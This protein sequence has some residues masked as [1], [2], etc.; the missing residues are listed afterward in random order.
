MFQLI[1]NI[2]LDFRNCFKRL[3]TW[4]WFVI[5]VTGFMVRNDHRG[6][7]S[8]ISSLR[9]R[10]E[11]YNTALH[12]FRS[13]GYK[14]GDL[15][16]KWVKI[17]V[18][19]VELVRIADR[20]VVLGDHIKVSKEGR[21][22][23]WIQKLHQESQNSGKPTFIEGNIFG[24]VSAIQTN[25]TVSRSLPLKTQLQASPPRV[26]GT[27]KPDGDTLVTQMVNLVYEVAK[28]IGEPVVVALDAYFSNAPAWFAADKTI[29]PNGEKLVE[30]V[31]RA[32]SNT[33]AFTVPVKPGVKK[34][35]RPRI[36]GDRVALY[37]LFSNMSKFTQTTLMLYGKPT[38]VQYRC[39]DL[40]WKPVKRL[41]RFVAVDLDGRR[42][43]LMSTS[44]KLTAE[45]IITI[46]AFRFKIETSFAEQKNDI[47]SFAYHFWTMALPKRKK[48]KKVELPT[49]PKLQK[50]I[51]ATKQATE[52]FVCLC[53]I[54]TG[55]LSI[56]AFSHSCDIWKR[57]PG[58]IRTLRSTIPTIAIVKVTLAND[59]HGFLDQLL[60]LPVFATIK[61]KMRKVEFLFENVA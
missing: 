40:I 59:I 55:I 24:Q 46:Y 2:L 9:L 27:K 60:Y 47:G 22:M 35:G 42:C 16:E 56:I 23:P 25:G 19:N 34:P 11:L 17:V 31:T 44:L 53:T 5:L 12:F 8:V 48:W 4:K 36:Y 50:K 43:V 10:P 14:V 32:Q 1:N 6:V 38:K 45:E 3:A 57:Y 28:S 41:V 58:W 26:E 18:K 54:A 15:Y 37:D 29:T 30:I 33:V 13:T 21:R 7:T 39:I 61:S 20:V 51:E 52:S 49:V